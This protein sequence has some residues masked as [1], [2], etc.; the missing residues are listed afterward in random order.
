MPLKVKIGAVAGG[1]AFASWMNRK[2]KSRY[3]T[4]YYNF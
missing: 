4:R 1:I 3:Y 2:Q